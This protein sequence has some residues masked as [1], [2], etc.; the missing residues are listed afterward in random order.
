MK[1]LHVLFLP[2]EKDSLLNLVQKLQSNPDLLNL[3]FE[4]TKGYLSAFWIPKFKFS[5][6]FEAQE[7]MKR[8]GLTLHFKAGDLTEVVDCLYSGEK[9]YVSKIFHKSYIEVNEEVTEAV[10]ST[11]A[12]FQLFCA[13]TFQALRLTVLSYL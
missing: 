1:I 4:L 7:T 6:E 10:A 2:D 5:F 13:D 9:L 3:Q 11:A 8:M 12:M